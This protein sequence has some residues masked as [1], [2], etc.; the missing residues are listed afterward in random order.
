MDIARFWN[1]IFIPV[2]TH[3]FDSVEYA[4]RKA[5]LNEKHMAFSKKIFYYCVM[6]LSILLFNSDYRNVPRSQ[7]WDCK[8]RGWNTG[9]G[10]NSKWYFCFMRILA[11]PLGT[12]HLD[13]SQSIPLA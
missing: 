11:S 5:S 9:Y 2:E 13:H 10:R 7:T 3:N 4:S 8:V 6:W 1:N 12:K